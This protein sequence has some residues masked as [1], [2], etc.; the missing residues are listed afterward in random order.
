MPESL[1]KAL[2]GKYVGA[3]MAAPRSLGLTATDDH[4]EFWE[5][6]VLD[7]LKMMAI[8]PAALHER[9]VRVLDVGSGNGVP[10]I[11]MAV[12]APKWDISLLDANSKKCGF[13]DM[14][15]KSNA[16]KNVQIVPERA[17]VAGQDP[18]LRAR[19]DLV[20]ARALGKL[21]T[22]L[23]LTVPF[24]KTGGLLVIPHGG[25][26]KQEL[27]RAEKAMKELGAVF[28]EAIPYQINPKLAF[29][30]LTFL[31]TV[32]TPARYPRKTGLPTKRPL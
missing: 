27:A 13:L 22:A 8:L 24:L 32:E 1:Q 23:E 3:V 5:R 21:P 7:A 30:A 4:A 20:F 19:F 15:C 12:A 2:L 28:K 16:L 9:P 31:K 6:H 17:E 26:H 25:S 29:T 14:F 18:E 10:G 11:P